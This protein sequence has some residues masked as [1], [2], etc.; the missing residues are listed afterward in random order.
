MFGNTDHSFLMKRMEGL[1]VRVKHAKNKDKA[2]SHSHSI[3]HTHTRAR[4]TASGFES[5]HPVPPPC[6]IPCP[7]AQAM[8]RVMAS[9][10]VLRMTLPYRRFLDP[11]TYGHDFQRTRPKHL[12]SV[13]VCVSA[14]DFGLL[15][16]SSTRFMKFRSF[17][18]RHLRYEAAF[19]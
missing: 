13:I 11:E 14:L 19:I 12:L 16:I 18:F 3:S 17:D 6:L 10:P 4:K 1:D 7:S 2:L 8:L 5:F 15:I 9:N